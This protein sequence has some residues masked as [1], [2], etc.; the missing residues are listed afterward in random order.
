M[1]WD[2]MRWYGDTYMICYHMTIH[3][4][5][6]D[7]MNMLPVGCVIL[8]WIGVV[9]ALGIEMEKGNSDIQYNNYIHAPLMTHGIITQHAAMDVVVDWNSDLVAIMARSQVELVEKGTM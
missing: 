7:D 4:M 9:P 2:D 1:I 5:I 6:W 8:T 3:E